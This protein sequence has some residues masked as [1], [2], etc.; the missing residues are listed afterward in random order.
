[1]LCLEQKVHLYFIYVLTYCSVPIDLN[2]ASLCKFIQGQNIALQTASLS[3]V[4]DD[5]DRQA[6]MQEVF[7]RWY[8]AEKNEVWIENSIILIMQC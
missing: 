8:H 5:L 4:N 1:M 7:S 2:E 6:F 3:A